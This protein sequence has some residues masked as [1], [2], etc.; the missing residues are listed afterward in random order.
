MTPAQARLIEHALERLA[1]VSGSL[2][3]TPTVT[4]D[5]FATGLFHAG[6]SRRLEVS[7][8][9]PLWPATLAHEIGHVEQLIAG[10]YAS[11][12]SWD[13]LHRHLTGQ[14]GIDRRALLRAVRTIQACELDAEK[15]AIELIRAFRVRLDVREYAR[16][17]NEYLWKH[18]IARRTGVWPGVN[19]ATLCPVTLI[20]ARDFGKPPQEFESAARTHTIKRR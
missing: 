2:L 9:H 8:G 18:E 16:H 7:I 1:V 15:H 10:R 5:R 14:Q 20:T 17:A 12:H 11:G 3:L 6:G 19:L 4:L 13:L